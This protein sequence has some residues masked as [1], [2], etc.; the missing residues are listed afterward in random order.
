[1]LSENNSRVF[2][3]PFPEG[4]WAQPLAAGFAK[5]SLYSTSSNKISSPFVNR[6]TNT[7]SLYCQLQNSATRSRGIQR[8]FVAATPATPR[9]TLH[10]LLEECMLIVNTSSCMRTVRQAR[11][12][13]DGYSVRCML[14][15]TTHIR[16]GR[17]FT[18]RS[19]GRSRVTSSRVQSWLGKTIDIPPCCNIGRAPLHLVHGFSLRHEYYCNLTRRRPRLQ[20]LDQQPTTDNLHPS[21]SLGYSTVN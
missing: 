8:T 4:E 11:T 6:V 16:Y 21:S 9:S 13:S 14:N 12:A 20:L 1:M 7:F 5:R 10:S 19:T 3:P 2:S 15:L 17:K 18:V